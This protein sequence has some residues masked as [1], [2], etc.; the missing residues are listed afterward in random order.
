MHSYSMGFI[1]NLKR[2]VGV[3]IYFLFFLF[4]V[5][6]GILLQFLPEKDTIL[7]YSYNVATGLI[8]LFGGII[9][10]SYGRCSM[11]PV[12]LLKALKF[13]TL[14]QF[15][16][17]IACFIWAYYNM[18][19]HIEVPFPSLA[20][21]FYVLYMFILAVGMWQLLQLADLPITS[22]NIRD[23]MVIVFIS[24]IVLYTTFSFLPINVNVPYLEVISTFFTP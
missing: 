15:I 4:I 3:Y 8:Y 12:H 7:N 10:Y 17:A 19:S 11:A 20:D 21:I 23:S 22:N 14:S 1:G 5:G 2:Y 16:Y 13:L 24:Y 6:W 9:G 18:V